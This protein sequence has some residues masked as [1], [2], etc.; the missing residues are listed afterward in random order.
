[1]KYRIKEDYVLRDIV[2]ECMIVPIK[3]S[4]TNSSGFIA[5][6]ETGKLIM[7]AIEKGAQESEIIDILCEEYSVSRETAAA[8]AAEFI[9][10]FL[11]MGIITK[12]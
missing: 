4:C 10:K 11:G 5:L 8:D 3:G 2:D 1:M 7:R 6:N 12:E 9:E